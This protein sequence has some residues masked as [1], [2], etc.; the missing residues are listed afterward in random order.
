WWV[1][2]RPKDSIFPCWDLEG[3]WRIQVPSTWN[4]A[5][6]KLAFYEGY[7]CYVK[8][9][10][11]EELAEGTDAFL[12]FD[13]AVYSAEVWLNGVWVGK[14]ECGYSPFQFR[15]TPYLQGQN[16]LMVFVENYRKDDR[17]PGMIYDWHNDGGL[18]RPVKIV[19]TPERHVENFQVRTA[20]DGDEVVL[21]TVASFTSRDI[22][23][24]ETIAV[25][26]PELGVHGEQTV[27]PGEKT[28]IVFRQ[29]KERVSLWGYGN[30]KLY[31][32]EVRCGEDVV[33]DEV[34]LREIKTQG[35]EILLNG[36]PIKLWG[37]A[38]HSEF[39]HMG[40]TDTPELLDEFF[41]KIHDLGC[42]FVRCAHYP[43]SDA[44]V[45]KA[46]RE[47][48]LLWEEVPAY[49]QARM[50]EPPVKAL[51]F[52]MM[53]E[54]IDRDL[55]RASVIIWSVSNE[56]EWKNPEGNDGNYRYGIECAALVRS[57]DPTRLI[58]SAEAHVLMNDTP[59]NPAQADDFSYGKQG[60]HAWRP[61]LPDAYYEAMD[62]LSMNNY[63]PPGSLAF[64]RN[65]VSGEVFAKY[66]KPIMISEF[67]SV[68]LR[69]SD[70]PLDELGSDAGHADVVRRFYESFET[71]PWLAGAAIWNFCDI[72]SPIQ[73]QWFGSGL[74][75]FRY[76]ITDE[77][78]EP[79]QVYQ[80]VK[81]FCH[82]HVK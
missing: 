28:A 6:E 29:P 38:T 80:V 10:T 46:D 1:N 16:R 67:G 74:G 82:K 40:R 64:D 57:L 7:A 13:G 62:I 61:S 56:C 4:T 19:Y 34:G 3:M 43:Y 71:M 53:R 23:T 69:G 68:S 31:T 39:K 49:W 32:V 15:V 44:F 66:N 41:A 81:D 42:N 22:Q 27:A 58:S 17:V 11:S 60:R 5:F 30:P 45:R 52:Q 36:K 14:H 76:G 51:A 12:C 48:I 55:N 25:A 77:N 8:D 65:A 26:I 54:M 21:T 72:R 70:A 47:G 35:P 50:D 37:L 33:T 2:E 73:W 59:W 20:L 78:W 18:I 9:F 63:A 79:K 24:P 75:V